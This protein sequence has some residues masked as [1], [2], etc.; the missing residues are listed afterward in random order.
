MKNAK[1]AVQYCARCRADVRA[2]VE[3]RDEV[4]GVRGDPIA[5]QATVAVCPG[6]GEDLFD[7]AFEEKN[8]AA[9]YDVYRRRHHLLT[10]GEIKE[11]RERYG[12]SQR[13][14]AQLL[15]WGKVTVNRYENG[16]LQNRAHDTVL[17]L[18]AD[19]QNLARV[20]QMAGSHLPEATR[21]AL[22]DQLR[23]PAAGRIREIAGQDG[24]DHGGTTP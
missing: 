3:T 4:F 19:P 20:V 12:L 11:L 13:A 18:I 21:H 5:I 23:A 8:I 22:Q 24:G 15:G 2:R 14:L 7:E 17:R 6:C 16:A 9:A 10:P 1:V